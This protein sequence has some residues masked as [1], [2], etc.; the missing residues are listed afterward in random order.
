M[1]WALLAR[2]PH[3]DASRLDGGRAATVRHLGAGHPSVLHALC[4]VGSLWFAPLRTVRCNPGASTPRLGPADC[5]R[6]SVLSMDAHRAPVPCPW[7][8]MV[9][10]LLQGGGR[11]APRTPVGLGALPYGHLGFWQ[12]RPVLRGWARAV[13]HGRR[14]LCSVSSRAARRRTRSPGHACSEGGR[15]LLAT[16]T[17]EGGRPL[18]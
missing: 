16:I 7:T 12:S 13:V 11:F 15:L 5:R 2:P 14:L 10:P 4:G 17:H 6:R 9:A 8:V 18:G 3:W 1:G